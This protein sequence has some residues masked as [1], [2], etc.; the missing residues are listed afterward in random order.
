MTY[1]SKMFTK[2]SPRATCY[3]TLATSR[4]KKFSNGDDFSLSKNKNILKKC[5][6]VPN[7]ITCCVLQQC[8]G[9]VS[10]SIGKFYE[11]IHITGEKFKNLV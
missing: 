1:V 4:P 8:F 11:L 2:I 3:F 6:Y 5:M 10:E 9:S 7:K